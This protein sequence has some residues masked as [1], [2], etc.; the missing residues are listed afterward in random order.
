MRVRVSDV[1]QQADD[2]GLRQPGHACVIRILR[3]AAYVFDS[4]QRQVN[5]GVVS[6][7]CLAMVVQL[8]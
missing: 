8:L 2:V 7:H 1:H 6:G 4:Q 5:A 3:V